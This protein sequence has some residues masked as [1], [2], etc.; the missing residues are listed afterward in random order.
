MQGAD[1][2]RWEEVRGALAAA[3]RQ[4]V[5]QPCAARFRSGSNRRHVRRQRAALLRDTDVARQPRDADVAGLRAAERG[6]ARAARAHLAGG[7]PRRKEPLEQRGTLVAEHA[8][9]HFEAMIHLRARREIEHRAA[10]AGLR[11]RCAVHDAREP[12]V[13]QARRRTSRTAR[14]SRRARIPA[15]DSSRARDRPRAAPTSRRAPSDRWR[16]IGELA[17]RAITAPVASV[18]TAP[19]GTSPE[20]LGFA[21]ADQCLLHQPAIDVNRIRTH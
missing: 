6:S 8:A 16:A 12:R 19:T 20:R 14:A 18:M 9:R 1:P 3:E 21:G 4:G 10:R 5:V 7:A 15:N 13:H 2:D 11:I 17:A